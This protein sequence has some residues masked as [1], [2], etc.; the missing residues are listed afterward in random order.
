MWAEGQKD[1]QRQKNAAAHAQVLLRAGAARSTA[2]WT[3][4]NNLTTT[5]QT[6]EL[7]QNEKIGKLGLSKTTISNLSI[8]EL[9]ALTGGDKS[10]IAQIIV[11]EV[12]TTK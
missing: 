12:G 10:K 3:K 2:R 7:K 6:F 5:L 1:V 11:V 4:A 9:S 8:L